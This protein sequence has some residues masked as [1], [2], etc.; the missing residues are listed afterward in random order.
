MS[1]DVNISTVSHGQCGRVQTLNK[2]TDSS[3]VTFWLT[4]P[5]YFIP[6]A[7]SFTLLNYTLFISASKLRSVPCLLIALIFAQSLRPP[8]VCCFPLLQQIR[9]DDSFRFATISFP[10]HR[11]TT[12]YEMVLVQVCLH[13]LHTVKLQCGSSSWYSPQSAQWPSSSAANASASCHIDSTRCTF[14]SF[15]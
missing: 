15:E 4:K 8:L 5:R 11:N 13:F 6:F 1:F 12:S 9:L 3:Q 10:K 7:F 2:Q 14:E